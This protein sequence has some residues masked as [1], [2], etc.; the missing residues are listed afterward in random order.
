[1][2]DELGMG[3]PETMKKSDDI[4]DVHYENSNSNDYVVTFWP[5]V[6]YDYGTYYDFF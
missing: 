6:L 2:G 3:V 5:E 1:M 4:E